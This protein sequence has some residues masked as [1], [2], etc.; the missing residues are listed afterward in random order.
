[1]PLA[2]DC[3]ESKKA[4]TRWTI[5]TF[6]LAAGLIR[7]LSPAEAVAACTPATGSNT[8]V[9]CTGETLNQGPGI[10]TGYG[11]STQNG[12]ALTVNSGASVTGTSDQGD[13]VV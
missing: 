9:T 1:V 3:P 5:C 13:R 12:L 4:M 2:V 7:S 6:L 10:N 8:T 11:D